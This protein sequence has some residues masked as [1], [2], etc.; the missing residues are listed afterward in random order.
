M[1][2]NILSGVLALLVTYMTMAA[3][4]TMGVSH[5][6]ERNEDIKHELTERG[7]LTA[8]EFNA[9]QKKFDSNRSSVGNREEFFMQLHLKAVRDVSIY[10]TWIPWFTLPFIARI[11]RL[12]DILVIGV[13]PLGMFAV[14]AFLLFEVLIFIASLIVGFLLRRAWE[15]GQGESKPG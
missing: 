8:E 9:L 14:S 3:I 6:N 11:K 4:S 1:I 5:P 12:V 13:I 15:R 10:F 2:R 7:P